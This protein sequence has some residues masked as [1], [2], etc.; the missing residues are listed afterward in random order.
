MT[1][2]TTQVVFAKPNPQQKGFLKRQRKLMH[3]GQR[4]KEGDP[5]VVDELVEYLADYA[6]EPVNR[7][8]AVELIWELSETQFNEVIASLIQTKDGAPP[9]AKS[10]S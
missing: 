7:E 3:L 9:L 6:V 1:D 8:E 10:D 5:N 2:D 4:F